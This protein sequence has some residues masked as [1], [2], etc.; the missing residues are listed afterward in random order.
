MGCILAECMLVQ[1]PPHSWPKIQDPSIHLSPCCSMAHRS[2]LVKKFIIMAWQHNGIQPIS[3]ARTR[4]MWGR[5][6]VDLEKMAVAESSMSM[7][8]GDIG[9]AQNS[10]F[11]QINQHC[12]FAFFISPSP[13]QGQTKYTFIF[14][15]N[16][17]VICAIIGMHWFITSPSMST[18]KGRLDWNES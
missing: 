6:A 9:L 15:G 2:H 7:R 5:G 4:I 11:R 1:E 13:L 14:I 8:E 18:A 12:W 10:S 16:N 17:E 3:S